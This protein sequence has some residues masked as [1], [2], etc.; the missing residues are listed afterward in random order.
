MFDYGLV[1]IITPTY[2]SAVYISATIDCIIAQTYQNWELLITDDCSKDNT[3]EIVKEYIKKDSRIKL[4]VLEKNYGG[5]V[6]R[7][8]SIEKAK[9]R[10]IAFCDSDD[11]WTP[12][13]LSIQIAFMKEKDCA[14]SY[15]SYMLCD[16]RD[17]EL[18]INICLRKLT[19]TR[20]LMDN[21]VGCL[22][23]VYDTNKIGK[24]YMPTI[25]KRQD[26]GL[27]ISVLK[28]CKVAY[29]IKKPIGY[30]RIREN[31]VSSNKWILIRYHAMLYQQML[32][33]P[34]LLGYCMYFFVN[35]PTYLFKTIRTKIVNL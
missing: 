26:W 32:R 11:R 16:E 19:Y 12:D 9:G 8:N 29:G 15:G 30:Y 35:L 14:F 22:S 10:Y 33:I 28:K 13:K 4:F 27:W 17:N 24:V 1:S 31:S 20:I 21:F 18:G 34:L 2:N 23:A 5:G 25:R 3:V 7:N 6:S